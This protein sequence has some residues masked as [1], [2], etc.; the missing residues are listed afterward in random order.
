MHTLLTLLG[1]LAVLALGV[2]SPGPSFVLVA[3]T[4]VAVSRRAG[5]AAAAGM[6]TGATLLCTAALLGLHAL[7]QQIPEIYLVLKIGGGVYLLVLARRIWRGAATPLVVGPPRETHAPGLMRQFTLAA[8]TMLSNPKAAVQ[9][10]VIFA[11]V[12]PQEPSQALL[13][14]LPPAVFCLEA[15]WYAVVAYGLSSARPRSV[16][17]RAKAGLDRA[18]GA[19]LVA[20]GIKLLLSAR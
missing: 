16:Y 2:V 8:G 10:G 15:G 18:V 19:V 14:A 1:I 20:L 3:R 17:L 12:L 6:A 9:Y 4:A 5:L 11:A 13:L 7:F